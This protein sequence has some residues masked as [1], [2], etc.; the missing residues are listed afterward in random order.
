MTLTPSFH[1][2]DDLMQEAWTKLCQ[3]NP[4]PACTSPADPGSAAVVAHA[5]ESSS[6]ACTPTLEQFQRWLETRGHEADA[7]FDGEPLNGDDY[8]T[9]QWRCALMVNNC[10]IA[11]SLLMYFKLEQGV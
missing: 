7:A 3:A 5:S 1:S 8:A 4:L 6:G 9:H 11:T 10:R 2:A